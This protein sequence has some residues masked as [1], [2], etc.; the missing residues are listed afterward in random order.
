MP[1]TPR[2]IW[3]FADNTRFIVA[4]D[5]SIIGWFEHGVH[6]YLMHLKED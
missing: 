6:D 5:S 2:E 1:S 4:D 3:G